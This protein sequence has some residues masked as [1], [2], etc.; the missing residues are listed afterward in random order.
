MSIIDAQTPMTVVFVLKT[1]QEGNIL[2]V[3]ALNDSSTSH[4]SQYIVV[5]WMECVVFVL[6][7]RILTILPIVTTVTFLY[8]E[9][10]AIAKRTCVPS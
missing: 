5:C 9:R 2:L 6:P 3:V 4:T 1:S 10:E 7:G 8:V